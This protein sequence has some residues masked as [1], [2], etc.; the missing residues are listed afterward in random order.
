MA[1]LLGL[2]ESK[3]SEQVQIRAGALDILNRLTLEEGGVYL[4]QNW[5][6]A[7]AAKNFSVLV[8]FRVPDGLHTS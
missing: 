5:L 2:L 1:G 3:M 4:M 8:T 7:R 6:L